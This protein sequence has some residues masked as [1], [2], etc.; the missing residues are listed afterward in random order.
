MNLRFLHSA[1]LLTLARFAALSAILTLSSAASIYAQPAAPTDLV[2]IPDYG[3][4]TISLSWA[5]NGVGTMKYEVERKE[6]GGA[7]A[8]IG[9]VNTPTKRFTDNGPLDAAKEYFYRVRAVGGGGNS[10]Y[11]GE[12]Q[13]NLKIVFHTPASD[14]MLHGW[15][16]TI[17]TA[18]VSAAGM[19]NGFH[20]GV[21]FQRPAGSNNV[22]VVAIRG[23]KVGSTAAGAN[24]TVII[25]VKVGAGS[26]FDETSHITSIPA[27]VAVGKVVRAGQEIGEISETHFPVNFTDHVHFVHTKTLGGDVIE[28]HPLAVFKADGEKDPKKN[29]PA[30]AHHAGTPAGTLLVTR[31]GGAPEVYDAM[32]PLF[33]DVDLIVELAD[34]M[35]TNPDQLP[36][37]LGYWIEPV[38]VL[39]SR[40]QKG[41]K[42][43][44]NPYLLFN[45]RTVWFGKGEANLNLM[46]R[47]VEATQDHGPN[48][49]EGPLGMVETY[50]WQNF[51]HF[52]VTNTKGLDGAKGNVDDTQVWNTNAQEDSPAN[53]MLLNYTGSPDTTQAT[54]ARF[55]DGQYRLHVIASDLIN[56]DV[57]IS[58][59]DPGLELRVENYPPIVTMARPRFVLGPL[60]R[61]PFAAP[62]HVEFNEAMDMT[63][64]P[65]G[66]ITINNGAA[67]AGAVWATENRITFTLNNLKHFSI[68]TVTVAAGLKDKPGMPGG[69]ALDG[70]ADGV[71]GD[72]YTFLVFVL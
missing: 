10:N 43:A 71:A 59:M 58:K 5:H 67:V 19:T 13:Q 64:N 38:K 28:R 44:K 3:G 46:N 26:E 29:K 52:I 30:L 53:D 27:A 16:D 17:G 14:E 11:S 62:G 7:Y 47:I 41:V 60:A 42:T 69:R 6:M 33:G 50:P 66:L 25:E 45:F 63:I 61:G 24:G 35:G 56:S 40:R 32:K 18:A 65:A 8:N 4:G 37:R 48:I 12:F 21:D 57:D 70:D 36:V 2:A 23:G 49:K 31:D 55:R 20:E 22:K 51:K 72:A 15:N 9:M 54:K 34:A 1:A 68:Y 39:G